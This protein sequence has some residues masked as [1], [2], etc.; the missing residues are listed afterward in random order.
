[1]LK[2]ILIAHDLSPEADQALR[3]AE[4][5]ARR[6][7]ARLSLVHVLGEGADEAA[8]RTRLAAAAPH[9]ELRLARGRAA[10]EIPAL[11]GWL[12]ADLLVL[13]DHHRDS[14]QGF[15]GATLEQILQRCPTPVLLA[16]RAD[17]APWQRALVP[18]DFSPC[19]SRALQRAA[20]LL[21]PEAQLHVA[22]VHEVAALHAG[23]DPEELAFQRE[24]FERLLEE[25]H[26]RLD[27]EAPP[28]RPAW[29]AGERDQCL[30]QLIDELQ[31][32]LLALGS[33]SRGAL[34]D[35]LLGSLAL[36]MLRQPPCDVLLVR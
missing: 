23:D 1:M 8:A 36:Q 22:H 4:Q 12:Q 19:A 32:H 10:V 14:P 15:S 9:A 3:R 18:L 5:L 7:G 35:A 34:A 16:V 25:E 13:G 11:A 33:H 21:E 17:P 2:H 6:Q 29:R 20:T 31:P 26:A 30:Q 28:L 24:L 27:A